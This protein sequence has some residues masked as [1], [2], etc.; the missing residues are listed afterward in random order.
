MVWWSLNTGMVKNKLKVLH[1]IDNDGMGGAQVLLRDYFESLQS[2]DKSLIEESLFVLRQNEQRAF[3]SFKNLF[4][5]TSK[6]IFSLKPLFE[7]KKLISEKEISIVHAHLI[8]SQFM[9]VLLKVFFARKIKLVFHEHGLISG[10][11]R[12]VLETLAFK[13]IFRASKPFVSSYIAVSQ[14]IQS[15][16]ESYSIATNKIRCLYNFISNKFFSNSPYESNTGQFKVGFAA[17]LVERKGWREFI[18][19]AGYLK[20]YPQI[21]FLLAGDGP[22]REKVLKMIEDKAYDRVTYIGFQKEMT[23]FYRSCSCFVLPSHWEPMG[24]TELEAQA[25]GLPVIVS[26]VEGLNEVVNNHVDALFFEMKNSKDLSEKILK[27]SQ[28]SDLRES[29]IKNGFENAKKYS[30]E[31]YHKKIE[32]LYLSLE[33]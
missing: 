14:S 33:S 26:D 32:T 16:I 27:L 8:R 6:S 5:S 17:R 9:A 1:L 4:Y 30:F 2:K 10:S 21:H 29:L 31:S 11:D 22:D 3:F 28:D 13:V 25:S 24:L 7:L 18:E 19:A 20:E 15:K 23:D 12:S